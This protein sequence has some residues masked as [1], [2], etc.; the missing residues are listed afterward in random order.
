[1]KDKLTV[2]FNTMKQIETKGESTVIMA[3]CLREIVSIINSIP[4]EQGGSDDN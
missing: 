1:M 4:E 2:L 3:D